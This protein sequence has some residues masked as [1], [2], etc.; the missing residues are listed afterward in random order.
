MLFTRWFWSI[1]RSRESYLRCSVEAS[2]R[3]VAYHRRISSLT[4][5]WLQQSYSSSVAPEVKDIF[6]VRMASSSA[7]PGDLTQ[8]GVRTDR[9]LPRYSSVSNAGFSSTESHSLPSESS[10]KKCF[11]GL[12]CGSPGPR[13]CLAFFFAGNVWYQLEIGFL[14]ESCGEPATISSNWLELRSWV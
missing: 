11:G 4:E 3:S 9:A 7:G 8:V 6:L 12:A 13:G 14:G 2:S 5:R 1:R 10:L